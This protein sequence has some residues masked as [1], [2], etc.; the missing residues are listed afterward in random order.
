MTIIAL[1]A[2]CSTQTF[3]VKECDDTTCR[4]FFGLG[5]SCQDT[6]GHA[7]CSEP[8]AQPLPED[9]SPYPSDLLD[10]WETKYTHSQLIAAIELT[11]GNRDGF[12]L[13]IDDMREAAGENSSYVGIICNG[14][15]ADYM[16]TV[17]GELS[18]NALV[19]PE[20]PHAFDA[21]SSVLLSPSIPAS[22]VSQLEISMEQE[23]QFWSL[24]PS[25][26]DEPD[27][28]LQVMKNNGVTQLDIYHELASSGE[29]GLDSGFYEDVLANAASFG[30]EVA[31]EIE[32]TGAPSL[33]SSAVS[34]AV[35]L[36]SSSLE[37][38]DG[39]V[40]ELDSFFQG[41]LFL[42]SAATL[43]RTWDPHDFTISGAAQADPS[44]DRIDGYSTISAL[45][46]TYVEQCFDAA[47]SYDATWLAGLAQLHSQLNGVGDAT[48]IVAGLRELTGSAETVARLSDKP[49]LM[50]GQLLISGTEFQLDGASSPL[51]FD[52]SLREPAS[53]MLGWE[54]GPEG[55]ILFYEIPSD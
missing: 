45:C 50:A 5:S 40:D 6:D 24:V 46:G 44:M 27:A 32:F 19:G 26:S 16:P 43:R 8:S 11:D 49:L 12:E 47:A 14:V 38:I 55:S 21:G 25:A 20:L 35:L 54:L 18:V 3:T 39:F 53:R 41:Q 7:Y 30:I 28:L 15:P 31:S 17:I 1:M 34:S 42:T 23:D 4:D 13:A 33:D 2:A 48:G 29:T 36:I 10:S 9:C 51:D 37:D 22:S 52:V